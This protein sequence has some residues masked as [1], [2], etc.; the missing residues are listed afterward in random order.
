[1][2]LLGSI[3]VKFGVD[4]SDLKSGIQQAKSLVSELAQSATSSSAALSTLDNAQMGTL[5]EAVYEV[6]TAIRDLSV[7]VTETTNAVNESAASNESAFA[8][9]ASDITDSLGEINSQLEGFGSEGEEAGEQAS[10]GMSS[11]FD[12]VRS[13]GASLLDFGSKIGQ[14]VFG[15]QSLGQMAKNVATSLFAPAMS[16]E[17]ATNSFEVFD[18]SMQKAQAE[19]ANLSS[20][21]AHTPFETSAIDDAALK[22]QAVGINAKS[23]IPDIQAL[24]DALDAGGRV[25]TADLDMIVNDFDKI[26]T[27]GHLTTDVMNSFAL[28]GVDAWSILE[29]QTGKTRAQL[30]DMVAK[31]LFP[32][33]DA[34]VDLTAGI[35]KS[36]LYSGQ[37]ANDTNSMTGIISTLKS[38]WDQALASFASP[39]MKDLEPVLNGISTDLSSPG[40]KSFAGDVGAKIASVFSNIGNVAKRVDFKTIGQD[41]QNL[42]NWFKTSLEPALEKA[43]PGFSSLATTV[44]NLAQSALPPLLSAVGTLIPQVVTLA[45]DVSGGLSTAI[46]AISA[47][48]NTWGP[49]VAGVGVTL[50]AAFI[51]AIINSGIQSTI[52]G[53]KIAVQ[54]VTSIIKT[55]AEGWTAAGKL[56][57]FIGNLIASG[58]QATWAGIQIAAQFVASMVTAGAQAVVAGAQIAASFIA[59][60]VEAGVQAAVTAGTFVADL[61]PAIISMT[62][63]ALTFALTAIPAILVGFASWVVGAAAVAIANIAAFW[64]IYLIVAAIV[65]V[66]GLVILIVK[67]W[68]AITDWL[69]AQWKRFLDWLNLQWTLLKVVFGMAVTWVRDAMSNAWNWITSIFGNIGGW[70]HDRWN[71]AVNR[72]K[73]ILGGLRDFARGIWS[74]IT[75]DV[76]GAFNAVIDLINNGISH[77]NSISSKVGIPAIPLI[78]HL[79]TGGVIPAGGFAVVGDP[80]PS[81]ELVYGG[82][83]GATVFS[84]GQSQAMLSGGGGSGSSGKQEIHIHIHM[85]S[86]EIAHYTA[87]PTAAEVVA[88]LFGHGPVRDAA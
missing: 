76:K 42:G 22:M 55:G 57:I 38:N 9:M 24:G 64:P 88:R 69:G 43:E 16:I 41:I 39:V 12:K 87:D 27:T 28:Q 23:V 30:G 32:A 2:G 63:D 68:G 5:I 51:P 53:G 79:S 66:I 21:A 18:G 84:H 13:G 62:A 46:T 75:G 29:K 77:L 52:A 33:K 3:T 81:S 80:G 67:N 31:G 48:F 56:A 47:N 1:M 37:M 74:T 73:T 40:F 82:T 45:G 58:A 34:M 85:D 25:S 86:S 50:T 10:S 54:F 44:G 59:N 15:L 7:D 72:V 36:P 11:F 26:Q 8:T 83:S 78:P 60:L 4:L 49:I 14:S 19:M 61:V 6:T 35:E 71:D 17:E 65:I 70:F 20:F